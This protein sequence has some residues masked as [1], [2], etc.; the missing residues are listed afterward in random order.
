MTASRRKAAV[1]AG[2]QGLLAAREQPLT[3]ANGTANGGHRIGGQTAFMARG[4][5]MA[6]WGS[7]LIGSGSLAAQ[8]LIIPSRIGAALRVDGVIHSLLGFT[9]WFRKAEQPAYQ[10]DALAEAPLLDGTH[11]HVRE[12]GFDLLQHR[13]QRDGE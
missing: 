12:F 2:T 9:P 8:S 11:F 4:V 1:R 6:G 5:P 3:L 13:R 10:A 7:R